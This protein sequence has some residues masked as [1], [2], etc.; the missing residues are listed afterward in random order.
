MTSQIVRS[1][2]AIAAAGALAA[3]LVGVAGRAVER[4]RLGATDEEGLSRVRAELTNRFEGAALALSARAEHVGAARDTI[5]SARRGNAQEQPLFELL[6]R[7]VPADL[8][9]TA[10][11]TVLDPAGSPIAWVGRGDGL[12]P[13]THRRPARA[14]CR[15]RR[16]RSEARAHRTGGGS[17]SA[18]GSQAG[19]N[20]G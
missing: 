14:V 4:A 10:G 5:R 2:A 8:S 15:T 7:E 17:G 11:L 1:V 6:D 12:T 20:R 18:G 13:R 19:H 9:A 16:Q 3:A